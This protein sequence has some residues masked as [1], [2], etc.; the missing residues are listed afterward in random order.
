MRALGE[1]CAVV[2]F[3]VYNAHRYL[4]QHRADLIAATDGPQIVARTK[5]GWE[6]RPVAKSQKETAICYY[7]G[8]ALR[9][10][11]GNFCRQQHA[12]LF[13]EVVIELGFPRPHK[14]TPWCK[15]QDGCLHLPVSGTTS[16]PPVVKLL[17]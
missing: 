16:N 8:A 13:A 6:V 3:K 17:K 11:A 12:A 9:R 4:A 2:T 15:V 5:H 10:N 1:G 14:P 7:C